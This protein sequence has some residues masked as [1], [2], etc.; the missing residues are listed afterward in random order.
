[1]HEHRDAALH[2]ERAAAPHEAVL[3]PRLEGRV[4][5]P[6]PGGRDDVHVALQQE[7]RRRPAR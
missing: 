5:P 7:R 3:D 1:V 6:L 2:V 4:R